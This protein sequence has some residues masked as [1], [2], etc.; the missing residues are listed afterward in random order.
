MV[1]ETVFEGG[2]VRIW[3]VVS[4]ILRSNCYIAGSPAGG[5]CAVIDPGLDGDAIDGAIERLGLAPVAVLCTHGHF[6]HVGSASN[7]QQK[8]GC[9]VYL[10]VDD[11]KTLRSANFLLMALNFD[12]RI[13]IPEVTPLNETD[14]DVRVADM[15]FTFVGSPGHTPGSCAITTNNLAFTGDTLY[16]RRLGLS[17][18]P[19]ENPDLLRESVL[20]L[21]DNLSPETQV[22]PGHGVSA[23]LDWILENNTELKDFLADPCEGP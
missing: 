17:R 8:Y 7:L 16:S 12:A 20:S 15:N 21:M 1:I 13:A 18:L 14:R 9:P 4:T 11:V 19:G 10:H 5:D 3:R 6:D 23:R 22:L 2:N